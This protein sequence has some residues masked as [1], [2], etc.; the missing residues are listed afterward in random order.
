MLML[1]NVIQ[2]KQGSYLYIIRIYKSNYLW[3][4]LC[5]NYCIFVCIF[6]LTIFSLFNY[7]IMI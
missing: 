1:A 5:S 6:L 2:I 7:E 4:I 3:L